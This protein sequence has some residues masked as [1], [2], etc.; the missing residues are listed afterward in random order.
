MR[1]VRRRYSSA[2]ALAVALSLGLLTAGCGGDSSAAT[3]TEEKVLLQSATA[4]GPDPFTASTARSLSSPA[5]DPPAPSAATSSDP[6]RGQSLRT[7]SGGTPGLYGGTETIGSCDIEQ[8]ITFLGKDAAKQ[9]AFAKAAGVSEAK[10]PAHLRS[11]TPVV[12]RA[13]TRVTGHGFE[14]G[15]AVARQSLL[16]AGT[17]VLVDEYG[18]PRVRCVG[19]NPLKAPVAVK[20]AVIHQGRPWMGFRPDRVVVIKPTAQAVNTLIIVNILDSTWI[21]R[22]TGSDGEQDRRPEVLPPVAPDDIF[23]Y[24]PAMP[25]QPDGSTPP[26]TPSE[27]AA[28]RDP[29]GPAESPSGQDVAPPADPPSEE[30]PPA[31]PGMP[32]EED[33]DPSD[34]NLL[35]PS[36]EPSE[37]DTFA[38]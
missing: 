21:E 5:P 35:I 36:D 29:P 15:S 23:T 27:P 10:V 4:P 25:P 16:Q 8:Q 34:P 9:R 7:L 32:S 30:L 1:P 24:P 20:G 37:P 38:G 33:V 18:A 11:L 6:A 2:M 26:N 19:G 14:D 28:P 31:D 13:D 22:K 17:P 12:L 3:D